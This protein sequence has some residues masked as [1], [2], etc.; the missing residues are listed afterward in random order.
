[1]TSAVALSRRF[2]FVRAPEFD[3]HP[4]RTTGVD[5]V[6]SSDRLPLDSYVLRL[7]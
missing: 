6:D 4:T 7:P 2:G 5:G 1:M 3:F